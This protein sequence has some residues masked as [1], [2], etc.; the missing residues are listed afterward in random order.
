MISNDHPSV[1]IMSKG[2]QVTKL[3]AKKDLIGSLSKTGM[4]ITC[5]APGRQYMYR[6]LLKSSMVNKFGICSTPISSSSG[7][8]VYTCL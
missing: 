7:N 6:S 2:I 4:A 8:I 1:K 3:P 5:D